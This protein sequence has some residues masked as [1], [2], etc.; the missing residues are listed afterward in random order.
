MEVPEMVLVAVLDP[1]Q[2]ERM[3]V[4]CALV[5]GAVMDSIDI[6]Q[7]TGAK[8]STIEP[9]FEN[10]DLLSLMSVAPTVQTDGSD[11]GL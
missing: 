1:I 9:K 6:S 3:L 2:V 7:L 8:M 11:A 10:E 5:S 4:P